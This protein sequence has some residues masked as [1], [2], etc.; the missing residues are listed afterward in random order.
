MIA[1]CQKSIEIL[2]NIEKNIKPENLKESEQ[3][4]KSDFAIFI[5]IVEKEFLQLCEKMKIS[6]IDS[7]IL[8]KNQC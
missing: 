4:H 5:M 8:L 7:K 6:R 1:S 2:C 3:M